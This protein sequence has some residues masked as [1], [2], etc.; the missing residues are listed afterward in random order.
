[1][2]DVAARQ[3]LR[4]IT[5]MLG[6]PREREEWVLKITN[7]NFGLEDPEFALEGD[8]REERLGFLTEAFRLPRRR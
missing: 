1:M 3:P 2:T 6:I 4:M 7:Q 8:T 5:E